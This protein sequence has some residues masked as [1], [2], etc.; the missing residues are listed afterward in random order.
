MQTKFK[1][2]RTVE[3]III[4]MAMIATD[5]NAAIEI[6]PP[7]SV[8][9]TPIDLA[10]D[11]PYPDVFLTDHRKKRHVER[12][13]GQRLRERERDRYR[14]DQRWDRPRYK[15]G[16]RGSREYRKGYRRDNDG[17]WYPLAAFALGAIILNQQNQRSTNTQTNR[18]WDHIPAGNMTAHDNWCAQRYRSYDRASK[19]FQPYNGPRKYCNSPYDLR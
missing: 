9:G 4:A 2:A 11:I 6:R 8:T 14:A 19:T 10:A 15:R 3:V 16:Y 12:N 17:W 7:A 13:R 1:K 18:N 5:A